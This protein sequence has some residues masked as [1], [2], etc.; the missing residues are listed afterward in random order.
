VGIAEGHAVTCAAG[1]AC[2]GL[3]P[4]VAIYS[5]FLQR[6]FDNIIHDVALQKLPVTFAVDRAGI[7]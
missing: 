4:V 6:S 2:E 5:T 3:R 7:V 1:M